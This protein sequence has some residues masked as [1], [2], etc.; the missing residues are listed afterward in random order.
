MVLPDTMSISSHNPSNY[1]MWQLA[2]YNF[3]CH[4][5]FSAVFML[6]SLCLH[7]YCHLTLNFDERIIL[8]MISAKQFM[9]YIAS[10]S[11]N[12]GGYINVA[13][14]ANNDGTQKSNV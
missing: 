11:K 7:D 9:P 14:Y 13:K 5:V 8:S 2:T 3:T 4:W 10:L 6:F 1:Y 12:F